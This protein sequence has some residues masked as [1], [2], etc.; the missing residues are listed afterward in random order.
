MTAVDRGHLHVA[1]ILVKNGADMNY[2][3]KVRALI[4]VTQV[5][6]MWPMIR[7]GIM[8]NQWDVQGMNNKYAACAGHSRHAYV[9]VPPFDANKFLCNLVIDFH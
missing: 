8:V 6:I 7:H 9:V 2:R 4:P 1:E 5:C 3:N